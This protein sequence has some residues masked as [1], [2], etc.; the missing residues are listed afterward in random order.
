MALKV[1]SCDKEYTVALPWQ[2]SS[3]REMECC[4]S[5]YLYKH[6]VGDMFVLFAVLK[7]YWL[8]RKLMAG[9]VAWSDPRPP[10]MRTVVGSILTSGNILSLRLVK[11]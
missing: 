4:Q 6:D 3:K 1:K 2:S 8:H 5:S 11:K 9:A 7:R 10:G